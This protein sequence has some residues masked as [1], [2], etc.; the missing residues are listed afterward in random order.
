VVI[1]PISAYCGRTDSHKN[2]DVRGL[3]GPL[4]ELAQKMRVAVVAVTHLNKSGGKAMYRAMGSLAFVAAARSAWAV[5]KDKEEPRRRL[6][7]P[8]KCNLAPD[9]TGLSYQVIEQ[10]GA[11]CLAWSS[12]PVNI[13]VDEALADEEDRQDR[14]RDDAKKW[15]QQVL[16][17]GPVAQKELKRQATEAGLAF[18]TVR[19][20]KDAIKVVVYKEGF[21]EGAHWL[22][23]LP[24]RRWPEG[25]EDVH[26]PDVDTFEESGH[27]R[28]FENQEAVDDF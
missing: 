22:W 13:A 7:L 16:A 11:P 18:R 19:R 17:D 4:S 21:G 15:L 2:A 9:I 20:A 5:V 6:V 27:L 12:E 8:I 14:D 25:A 10:C 3:L 26:S 23:S 24:D 1:D 28:T